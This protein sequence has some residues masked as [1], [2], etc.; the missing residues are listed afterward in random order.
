MAARGRRDDYNERLVRQLKREA[1]RDEARLEAEDAKYA[2]E[3]Y[4]QSRLDEAAELTDKSARNRAALDE[5]LSH[6][7]EQ[8]VAPLDL[9]AQKRSAPIDPLR[10]GLDA[11]PAPRP[12]WTSFAPAA[13]GAA[14]RLL[15]G[16]A[17]HERKIAEARDRFEQ[18]V[19]AY[20]AEEAARQCRVEVAR[21]HHAERQ[22]AAEQRVIAENSEIDQ[23]IIG[24]QG[25]DRRAVSGYYQRLVNAVADPAEFPVARRTAY[26][27]ESSL[28]VVEW[29][30]PTVSVVPDKTSFKYVR[31]RDQIDSRAVPV[32]ERRKTYQRLIAQMA[33]RALR[34]AFEADPHDLVDT[35]V[36]NGMIDDI[37]PATGQDVRR[38]LI[39][40]RATREQ[41][42]PLVLERV[43]PVECIRRHFAADVS[44]HPDELEAVPP[45]L[46]FD[47][48]D[49]RVIDP[50]DVLSEIDRRPNLLDLTPTQFE[51]FTQNLFAKMGLQVQVFKP[52]GD[53]GIDCVA[54]DP[55]PIFGGKF[56]IQAKLYRGT[57]PPTHVRDLYGAVVHEGATRGLLITT[58]GFGPSSYAWANGKPLELISG[59]GLLALCHQHGIPARILRSPRGQ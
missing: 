28:L 14:G 2:K 3:Q 8:P 47:M 39:T 30:L 34:L 13:P 52:G 45:V 50:I 51:H 40:L 56:C 58:G 27:P 37:D 55:R 21:R 5:L 23:L 24:V 42:A 20:E 12:D 54:Y 7:L 41:F 48:V 31:T 18:A 32:A 26:V 4:L 59:S 36:F 11:M 10:L 19:A 44:E 53:G 25:G 22:Q 15:G 9:Q 46:T 6:A 38:C 29:D 43:N 35:V 16:N 1:A 33:L 17:R 57:V 49:P